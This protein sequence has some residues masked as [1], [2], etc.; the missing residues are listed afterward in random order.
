MT[1]SPGG[2]RPWQRP[3][4][5]AGRE[6]AAVRDRRDVGEGRIGRV[7]DLDVVG[8]AVAVVAHDD[9]VGLRRARHAC[10]GVPV[11]VVTGTV[12]PSH[13]TCLFSRT[14][15]WPTVV[16]AVVE[17]DCSFTTS[18]R[19]SRCSSLAVRGARGH[20]RAVHDRHGARSG[21]S[22]RRRPRP[23]RPRADLVVARRRAEHPDARTVTIVYGAH[24]TAGAADG[25]QTNTAT[26]AWKSSDSKDQ[27]ISTTATTTVGH[28]VVRLNKHVSCDGTTPCPS[29]TPTG[30]LRGRAGAPETYSIVVRNDGA[31]PGL[32][33]PGRRHAL[34]PALTNITAISNGGALCG[35]QDH[36]DAARPLAPGDHVT[37]T[38]NG[39]VTPALAKGQTIVNTVT[40]PHYFGLP[41]V[42][43]DQHR[44][45]RRTTPTRT[46]TPSR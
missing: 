25:K 27:S 1:W 46:A 22:A 41:K 10:A 13:E 26:L 40:I 31:P 45:T 28:P 11:R 20:V 21:C 7:D 8:R 16:V 12:V 3:G 43:R 4:D 39:V 32:R 15:G 37:L 23:P 29:R 30:H 6:G 5:L 36:L 9:R 35:R 38:Y 17:I 42:D 34:D 14:T 44:R 19:A 24:V 33:H 18:R 2:Q